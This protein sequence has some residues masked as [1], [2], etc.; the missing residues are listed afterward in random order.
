MAPSR[1]YPAD[2]VPDRRAAHGVRTR[3]TGRR[4]KGVR[5][6]RTYGILRRTC[7]RH[8]AAAMPAVRAAAESRQR[9]LGQAQ[10]R[11]DAQASDRRACTRAWI[12]SLHPSIPSM[13]PA[14][15]PTHQ[16]VLNGFGLLVRAAQRRHLLQVRALPASGQGGDGTRVVAW[17]AALMPAGRAG[18]DR[19][20]RQAH[21][22]PQL[23]DAVGNEADLGLG[24]RKL[25]YLPTG[26]WR[27]EHCA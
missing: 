6:T 3:T 22:L 15:P 10:V 21:S 19:E 26:W 23:L 18:Q 4:Q 27:M 9:M 25:E 13:Q 7:V 11:P 8:T 16:L 12:P 17:A 14:H 1:R 5:P 2:P 24:V 20:D